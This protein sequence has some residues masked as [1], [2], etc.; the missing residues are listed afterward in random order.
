[1]SSAEQQLRQHC[2]RRRSIP[3]KIR[4][5]LERQQLS[6]GH[7][8]TFTVPRCPPA[9]NETCEYL[10]G[11]V[12]VASGEAGHDPDVASPYKAQGPSFLQDIP[13][14]EWG[15]SKTGVKQ[16][17][18]NEH[19]SHSLILGAVQQYYRTL[20]PLEGYV[21]FRVW[22]A[23]YSVEGH[24]T[25]QVPAHKAATTHHLII[26]SSSWL[27][28]K[29]KNESSVNICV[30]VCVCVCGHIGQRIYYLWSTVTLSVLIN[31]WYPGN[32]E[33]TI[34]KTCQS[35]SSMMASMSN[36]SC[37]SAA[38]NWKNVDFSSCND[39]KDGGNHQFSL[40][41]PWWG[42][43]GGRGGRVLTDEVVF[44]SINFVVAVVW[45]LGYYLH[46]WV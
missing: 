42:V 26:K 9:I 19:H 13:V 3:N 37:C 16:V 33:V 6:F 18:K 2:S 15:Q 34:E 31:S 27:P 41:N 24:H 36:A 28:I 38:P 12:W 29:F 7:C 8:L 11:K 44:P 14:E 43:G 4:I 17:K 5:F 30:R 22:V 35:Y 23:V 1:M 40:K 20:D 32:L 46:T 45:S 21:W 39:T 10:W 25:L